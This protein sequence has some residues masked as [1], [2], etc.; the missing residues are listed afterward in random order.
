[1]ETLIEDRLNALQNDGKRAFHQVKGALAFAAIKNQS[2]PALTCA[3]VLPLGSEP[4]K[5]VASS[6]GQFGMRK[7]SFAVVLGVQSRN[8]PTGEKGNQLIKQLRGI[9]HSSMQGW[10]PPGQSTAFKRGQDKLLA[11]ADNGLWWINF[12]SI[13]TFEEVTYG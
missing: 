8:D 2:V 5:G 3:Y 9:T 4:M 10:L 11:L 1:M 7:E 6:N 12:Y 13:E